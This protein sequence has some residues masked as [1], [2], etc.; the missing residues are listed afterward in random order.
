MREALED[1]K[2]SLNLPKGN[3]LAMPL[4]GCGLDRLEWDNVR[5]IV[6]EVFA[7]TNVEITVYIKE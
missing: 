6:Q 3:K 2:V 7:D 4:I 5:E 1:L